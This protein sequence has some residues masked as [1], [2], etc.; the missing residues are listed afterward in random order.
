MKN[1]LFTAILLLCVAMGSNAQ[2][3]TLKFNKD[4]KF[5]IV[6]FTDLHIKWQ[7]TRSDIAFTC[8]KNTLEAEKP[9]LVV[10][11][12]DIIY[13]APADKNFRHVMEF[14]SQYKIPFALAF[15][16]HD[17]EQGLSNAELLKIAREFP[18]CV[19]SDVENLTGDGN[20]TLEVKGGNGDKNKMILYFIDSNRGSLLEEQGVGGYDYIH[21]DQV[22]WYV[23]TSRTYTKQNGG[24]PLPALA[25]FH[26][27]L[28]EYNLAAQNENTT[29]Y[30]I[31]REKACSPELNSGLFAAMKGQGDI[32]GVFVGHDHDNDYAV[33]WYN[34]LLAYGRFTGGPTEYIHIPNGARVIELTEGKRIIDT[35]IRLTNGSIEQRTSFPADY[36]K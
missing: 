11:T 15:G 13:S 3:N 12:G 14:I 32:M 10:L 23:K 19:A 31:R 6:Q 7:D 26:I 2:T 29:L 1:F 5:K 20:Y 33:N 36:V 18:Y 8:I 35:Y 25:F 28:P 9:D 17:R 21:L 4:G 27:P 34:I 30:G 22:N 16:N 24:T